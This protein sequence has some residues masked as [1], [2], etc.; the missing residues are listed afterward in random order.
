MA[1]VWSATAAD[2][3]KSRPALSGKTETD[4][5]VVG[6]GMAGVLAAH[7]LTACGVKCLLVEAKELGSGIT[8]NTTAKITAQHGLIYG[9][10]IRRFGAEAARRYYEAN[11]RAVAAF[12]TLASAFPCDFEEK[13]AYVFSTDG[14][15]ALEL[16]AEA[17]RTLGLPARIT[18]PRIPI[19]T[20]GALGMAGQAQ[21]HPLKLLFALS[22]RLEV[23]E[24]TFVSGIEGH[25]AFTENGRIRAKHIILAT[26]FP[27]VNIPGMYFMKLYQHRSYVLALEGAPPLDGMYLEEREDGY[28]FRTYGDLLLVG[29]GDHKTGKKGG[30]YSELRSLVKRAF[31]G[32]SER[33]HWAA[34]DCMTLDFVPYVGLHRSGTDYLYTACGF[35]KWGMTGSMVAAEILCDLIVTGKSELQELYS[36]QRPMPPGQLFANIGAAAAGLASPGGPRCSHMG[37]K[38][39]WNSAERTWDCSCHGSRFR[40]DGGIVDNPAKKGIHL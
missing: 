26:H 25:T 15:R 28:S 2:K 39:H 27:M 11:M 23:F 22:E 40:E 14:R 13:T 17:Y 35:N 18:S 7:K 34:Q 8:G 10:L 36:P 16:E 32:A 9:G 31:P 30:G 37:C 6:G 12:R 1:S 3:R 20:K 24:N 4:V 21:F 5:L 19:R 29:G 38:L 33:F